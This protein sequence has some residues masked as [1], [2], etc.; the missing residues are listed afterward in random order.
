MVMAMLLF[1]RVSSDLDLEELDRR[2][3]ERKPR[4]LE[5]PGLIQKFYGRDRATGDTC[6]VY[7]FET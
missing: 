3:N 2:V 1:V 7:L 6:G 5:V 4:F